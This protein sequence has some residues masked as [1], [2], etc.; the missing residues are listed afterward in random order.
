VTSTAFGVT[1]DITPDRPVPLSGYGGRPGPF[2]DIRRP[3]E[4]NV[5]GIHPDGGP[6]VFLV[7]VD[8]LYGG[9]LAPRLRSRLSL[10]VDQL[11]V[12]GSH[13]HYAPGIDPDLPRLGE[14]DMDYVGTVVENIAVAIEGA[15]HESSPDV[16][17]AGADTSGLFVNRRR[18]VSGIGR[19]LPRVG[20]IVAAPHPA[21]GVDATIRVATVEASG[22]VVAILWGASCHPVSSPGGRALSPCFPGEV[23]AR[24]RAHVGADIPVVFC[25]G[26][27][28]DVRPVAQTRRPPR[29]LGAFLPYVAAGFRRFDQPSEEA[30]EAWCDE[31]TAVALQAWRELRSAPREALTGLIR[32]SGDRVPDGWTRAPQMNRVSLSDGLSILCVNAEITQ[33]RIEDLGTFLPGVTIPAGCCDEVIGYWPTDAMLDEGGY[34]GGGSERFFPPLAWSATGGPDALWDRMIRGASASHDAE[35]SS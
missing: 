18:P 23:R 35:G 33:N 1:V 19:W 26:F 17:A 8:A 22:S 29:R 16:G 30:Y 27:S 25:Q 4:A 34:E 10:G 32:R 2:D 20:H 12:L 3:I 14:T 24:L 7:A 21:G 9:A 13:T 6:P 11:V 31:L 5:L 28:A 15:R